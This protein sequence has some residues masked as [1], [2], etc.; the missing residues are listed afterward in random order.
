MRNEINPGS[1]MLIATLKLASASQ[2]PYDCPRDHLYSAAEIYVASAFHM[3]KCT[4]LCL[5]VYSR[6]LANKNIRDSLRVLVFIV[7]KRKL[8]KIFIW[9]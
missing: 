4:G 7:R 6:D 8:P 3:Y 2:L 1:S 9:I 5:H